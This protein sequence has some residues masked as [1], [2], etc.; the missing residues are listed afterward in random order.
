MNKIS[1]TCAKCSDEY[2]KKREGRPYTGEIGDSQENGVFLVP[3]YKCYNDKE[4][5]AIIDFVC[6]KGH[7]TKNILE[8]HVPKI[9]T[10]GWENRI[11]GAMQR[12][13]IL[14]YLGINSLIDFY[15]REAI[16]N[17][18]SS[19]ERFFEFAIMVIAEIKEIESDA[20]SQAWKLVE[21]QPERQYGAFIFAWLLLEKGNYTAINPNE[22]RK[23]TEI[24]NNSVH[25]G[26]IASENDCIKYGTYVADII[27][28]IDTILYEKYNNHYMS[29]RMKY[30][31]EAVT[32]CKEEKINLIT[33]AI[34][35]SL[36]AAI[37]NGF[38]HAVAVARAYRDSILNTPDALS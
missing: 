36:G 24:R 7:K 27:K 5:L 26:R 22:L 13:E 20:L 37:S 6:P 16:V 38:D 10:E 25:K 15:Y 9:G 35:C 3:A 33:T 30:H 18:S 23:I 31:K 32:K 21:N 29:Y 2:W 8:V 12:H 28:V 14:F 17:F 4:Q 11:I 34:P 19:L 1:V